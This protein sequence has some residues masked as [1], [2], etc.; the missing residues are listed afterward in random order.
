MASRN[1]SWTRSEAPPWISGR[2]PAGVRRSPG[3]MSGAPSANPQRVTRPGP[4]RVQQT[5]TLRDG[6]HRRHIPSPSLAS[7]PG[8]TG[9]ADPASVY[10]PIARRFN[11]PRFVASSHATGD[12]FFQHPSDSHPNQEPGELNPLHLPLGVH[13]HRT[14]GVKHRRGETGVASLCPPV[15]RPPARCRPPGHPP[16]RRFG[17]AGTPGRARAD[18][19]CGHVGREVQAEP[20]RSARV[21]RFGAGLRPRRGRDRQVSTG[22]VRPAR[23]PPGRPIGQVVALPGSGVRKG[24]GRSNHRGTEAQRNHREIP[25][26]RTIRRG[27]SSRHR[28]EPRRE[29]GRTWSK[30]ERSACRWQGRMIPATRCEPPKLRGR[31]RFSMDEPV[32]RGRRSARSQ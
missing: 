13:M 10:R 2:G 30:K 18:G 29:R 6:F 20:S 8:R 1:V 26:N 9:R 27:T 21:S 17:P 24:F 4:R 22:P 3:D 5:I 19:R 11:R 28:V 14:A 16:S 15:R 25:S 12:D 31:T 32:K 7:P 23:R